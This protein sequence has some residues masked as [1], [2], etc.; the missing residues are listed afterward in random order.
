MIEIKLQI[1]L[2]F[3]NGAPI[4]VRNLLG[5]RFRWPIDANLKLVDGHPLFGPS[6]TVRG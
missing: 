5:D 3:A 1:L 2:G 4:I 6:K